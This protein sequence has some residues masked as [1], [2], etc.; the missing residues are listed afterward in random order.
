MEENCCICFE[1]T[2]HTL[3]CFHH[4]CI[5]C[6][7]THIKK[8]NLCCICRKEFNIEPYKYIPPRFTPNLK[9]TKKIIKFFNKFLKSRYLLAQNKHQAY[10]SSLMYRFHDY[11][12]ANGKYINREIISKMNKYDVLQLYDYFKDKKC[13]WRSNIKSQ[14]TYACIVSLCQPQYH[15]FLGTLSFSSFP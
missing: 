1:P 14:M 3:P 13:K 12:Y 5:N 2:N 8:S 11:I 4:H 9:L 6:L 10:Y 7:K 15:E